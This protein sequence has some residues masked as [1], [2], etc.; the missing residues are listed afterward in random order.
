MLAACDPQVPNSGEGV[1]FND[2]AEFELERARREAQLRGT[3]PPQGDSTGFVLKTW[4]QVNW[5]KLGLGSNRPHR[6]LKPR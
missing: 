2:Y 6:H 5:P 4:L 1:G 3:A